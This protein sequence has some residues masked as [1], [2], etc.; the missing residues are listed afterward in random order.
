MDTFIDPDY[1][2]FYKYEAQQVITYLDRPTYIINFTINEKVDFVSYEGKLF[3]DQESFALVHAEFSLTKQGKK[4]ARR[5]LIKKK[6]RSFRVRPLDMN[7]QVTYKETDGKLH[8]SSAQTSVN[9]RVRSKYDK[10]NSIFHSVSDLLITDHKKTELRRFD[11]EETYAPKDIFS[12]L[13]IDY[14]PDF[15]GQYN[16]IKPDENL[17]KAVERLQKANPVKSNNKE[18][19]YYSKNKNHNSKQQHLKQ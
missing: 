18:G 13:I 12:E 10:I 15:W 17:Q 5:T 11:R 3:I 2:K 8:L 19:K 9:F 14:D 1:R 4:L 16:V 7:Y 6:P